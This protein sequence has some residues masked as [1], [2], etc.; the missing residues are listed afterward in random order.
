MAKA[1]AIQLGRQAYALGN[2]L[3]LG[4]RRRGRDHAAAEPPTRARCCE[5]ERERGRY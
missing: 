4:Q 2:A 3:G 5:R 1:M